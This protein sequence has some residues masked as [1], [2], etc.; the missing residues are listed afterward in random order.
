MTDR[1]TTHATFAL[2]R[3]YNAPVERVFAAWGDPAAKARWFAG[4]ENASSQGWE[5]E[6][7]F[8]VGGTERGVGAIEEG[9]PVYTYEGWFHD[10]VPDERIVLTNRVLR[11]AERISVN[12]VS[13]RFAAEGTGT[14]LTVTDHG[15]YLDGHDWAVWREAG[16]RDQLDRLEMELAPRPA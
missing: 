8:R 6:V 1:S 13:V 16:T 2:E 14:R 12:L 3:V 4:A 15:A 7:D 9:G 10:I 11:D 5:M